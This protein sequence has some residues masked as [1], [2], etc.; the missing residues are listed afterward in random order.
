MPILGHPGLHPDFDRPALVFRLVRQCRRGGRD[1]Q[2]PELSGYL[3]EMSR[4]TF[5]S[6][7]TIEVS[8]VITIRVQRC[9]V[10]CFEIVPAEPVPHHGRGP[11]AGSE[12]LTPDLP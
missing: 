3:T 7:R 5:D 1:G 9:T 6:R 4:H 11:L 10:T 12:I 2:A 8:Q